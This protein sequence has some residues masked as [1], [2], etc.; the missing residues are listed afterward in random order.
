[1]SDKTETSYEQTTNEINQEEDKND[2]PLYVI[3]VAAKLVRLP[4]WTLRV[5][6]EQGIVVPK[7]TGKNRRLYSDTDLSKLVRV[8]S[9]TE[10]LGV[11]MNGVRIIL[12]LEESNKVVGNDRQQG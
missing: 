5:L 9:L 2:T 12:Q 8:R 11:N 7:R 1:L 10:E 4:A 3:S 6:D